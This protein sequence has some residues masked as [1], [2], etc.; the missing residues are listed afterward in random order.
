M[1]INWNGIGDY[2]LGVWQC[3]IS[4]INDTLPTSISSI[5]ISWNTTGPTSSALSAFTANTN[6]G[7][8]NLGTTFRQVLRLNF[9]L[10]VTNLTTIYYLNFW[11]NGGTTTPNVSPSYI[12]FTR[13][14]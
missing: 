9:V 13:I 4:I 7:F 2:T 14:A 5:T 11:W 6:S 12:R 1:T 3:E 10:S 8:Y